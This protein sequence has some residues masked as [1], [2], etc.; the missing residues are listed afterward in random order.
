M[1]MELGK[2]LLYLS[3]GDIKGMNIGMPE[4][5]DLMEKVY[6]EKGK[7][8]TQMPPKPAVHSL[9]DK[10]SGDFIHAMPA[11]IPGMDAIGI[12]WVSGYENARDLGFPYIS[13]LY[14]LNDTQ[15][16]IPIAVMDCVWMTTYRT[17]A[18]TGLTAKLLAN[19]DSESI[20]LLGTG[21]QGRVQVDAILMVMNNIKEVKVFDKIPAA[22]EAYVK[23]MSAKHPDVKFTIVEDRVD[24]VKGCDL[25]SSCIPCSVIPGI[26]FITPD[27]IKPGC[28]ALPVDDL[29]LY[30]PGTEDCFDKAYTDD[31][32]QFQHFKDMGFFRAFQELPAE[33]GEVIVGKA[34]G[35][36]SHDEKILTVNIGTGL[37]DVGTARMLYDR[38]IAE[39]IG[40][41]LSL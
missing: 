17:A 14:I 32:G 23:E 21:L 25:L 8:L 29:V 20:G 5:I 11:F 13:G 28:T 22:A 12:K 37:A 2:D 41:K 19:P 36:T 15:T 34:E 40:T 24:A 18:V 6:A 38:A 10:Y 3:Q 30:E 7:G 33:L 16:G 4:M 35:R 31:R 39:G 26:E 27:M 9:P 1:T